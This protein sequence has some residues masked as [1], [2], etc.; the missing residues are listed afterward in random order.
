M[1]TFNTQPS[2][3][4]ES[5]KAQYMWI[6]GVVVLLVLIFV[7]YKMY[8]KEGTSGTDGQG[9]SQEEALENM[10]EATGDL[11][12]EN[13]LPGDMVYVS[14]VTLSHPGFVAISITKGA[15]AGKVIGSKNFP[16]GNNPGQIVVSEKTLEGQTYTA[17]LY[18]DDGDEKLDTTKDRVLVEKTFRATQYLDYI[19]G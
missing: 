9:Y 6:I 11:E 10:A 1:D 8:N 19:K 15:N 14:S 12:I 17:T 7:G 2:P 13:Q 3:L 5:N 4:G 18:A 16:E